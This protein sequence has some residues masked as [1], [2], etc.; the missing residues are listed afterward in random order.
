MPFIFKYTIDTLNTQH[1][2]ATGN[3]ILSLGS[4]SETVATVATSLLI[5]CM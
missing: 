4:A 3:A 1:M 2:A 5:G